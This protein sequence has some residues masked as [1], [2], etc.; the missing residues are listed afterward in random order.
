MNR[1]RALLLAAAISTLCLFAKATVDYDHA[2][3]FAKYHTYSWISVDVQEPLWKD[4]VTN[5][6]D[7]QLN[8]KG[9]HKVD[10]GGDAAIS[11]VGANSYATNPGNLV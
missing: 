2:A 10:S 11:A 4:R 8:A 7:G 9:W 3:N 1:N 6:V 5:A